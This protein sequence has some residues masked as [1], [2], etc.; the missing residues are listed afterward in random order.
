[1]HS[2]KIWKAHTST[3]QFAAKFNEITEKSH[4]DNETRTERIEKFLIAEAMTVGVIKAIQLKHYKNPN[5]WAKHLAPWF[6]A[7]CK[8]ARRNYKQQKRQYGKKH[9]KTKEAYKE[10]RR[11]CKMSRAQL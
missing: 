6:S 11:I 1:M 10:F 7:I 2:A 9:G 5:R 4:G 3:D 8:D